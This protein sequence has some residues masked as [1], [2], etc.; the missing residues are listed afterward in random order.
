MTDTW[1]R[2]QTSFTICV[3][4]AYG[5]M[6]VN[7]FDINQTNALVKTMHA[8]DHR[9]IGLLVQLLDVFPENR[10]FIDIGANLG[11]YT[12]GIARH[13]GPK[14][15]VISFEAQRILSYMLAGSIALNGLTNVYCYN[16]AVG[17]NHATIEIPQFDYNKPLNFGSVE[18][19]G[20]QREQL[21]QERQHRDDSIDYVE[22]IPLDSLSLPQVNIIKI[23]V[24]GMEADVLEG[25]KDTL[26]RCRPILYVEY[27]KSD[28]D[29]L[30]R[31]VEGL[32]YVVHI[33]PGNLLCVPRELS[34]KISV[35]T[36]MA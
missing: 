34:S 20:E 14:G 16:R 35:T 22:V 26:R 18:F 25:A 24:E 8:V 27:I 5:P 31:A 6:L 30:I 3:S 15:K 10:V 7:R 19:G 21:H 11:T 23:D 13:V 32:D 28:R 12:L 17:R 2:G 4:T 9:D 1:A 29:G 33:L 36:K